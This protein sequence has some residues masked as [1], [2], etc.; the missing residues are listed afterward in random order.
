M[1]KAELEDQHSILRFYKEALAAKEHIR[2]L[3]AINI[4]QATSALLL[5]DIDIFTFGPDDSTNPRQIGFLQRAKRPPI[6]EITLVPHPRNIIRIIVGGP[7][8][9]QTFLAKRILECLKV[10]FNAQGSEPSLGKIRSLIHY[11]DFFTNICEVIR[12]LEVLDMAYEGISKLTRATLFDMDGLYARK[13]KGPNQQSLET[14]LLGNSRPLQQTDY[15]AVCAIIDFQVNT[16][17]ADLDTITAQIKNMHDKTFAVENSDGRIIALLCQHLP[18]FT[19]QIY[20]AFEITL[21]EIEGPNL[22]VLAHL[23]NHAHERLLQTSVMY[24]PIAHVKTGVELKPGERLIPTCPEDLQFS[25][26]NFGG[27]RLLAFRSPR[28]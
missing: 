28:R 12:Q 14:L 3:N 24:R 20:W 4:K 21:A 15:D 11:D 16:G 19:T 1:R 7:E 18:G 23:F 25:I 2:E 5:H 10:V 9:D 17:K 13:R 6:T 22:R 26:Q 8:K 27:K